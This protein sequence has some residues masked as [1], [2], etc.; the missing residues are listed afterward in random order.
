M[1]SATFSQEQIGDF[2]YRHK[3][4]QK[5]LKENNIKQFVI[6]NPESIFYLI[7]ASFEAL[8]RVIL[9]VF[10][11]D[12]SMN[13]LVPTL[14]YSHLIKS[15]KISEENIT[16]Y[17]EFPSVDGQN[18]ND[19][20]LNSNIIKKPLSIA[21]ES[22]CPL[23]VASLFPNAKVSSF[24]D[25]I[26]TIKSNLE[27]EKIK[28]AAHYA[29]LGVQ[30]ILDNTKYGTTAF[31]TAASSGVIIQ[32][33]AQN[34]PDLDL[35]VSKIL[36]SVAFPAPF[37]GEPHSS[38]NLNAPLKEGPHV[39]IVLTQLN[40]YCAESERTFFTTEPTSEE[41][42]CFN[43]MLQAREI[44]LKMIKPGQKCSEIDEAISD[45]LKN[46]GIKNYHN[47][48]H[49]VGH[50]FGLSNH[51]RPWLAE[52]GKEY[53]E[54]NMLVSMEPGIYIP[55]LGGFRH[56]DTILVTTDGA[57]LLTKIPSDLD[58]LIIKK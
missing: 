17:K 44:G 41:R 27:I 24:V 15:Y 30:Y 58:S 9:L 3:F 18:W 53:L 1:I 34:I 6:T 23:S 21:I 42:E 5:K 39:A 40:G 37:S 4:L 47:Q 32:K 16:V 28:V 10:N 35:M 36:C 29:D 38:F 19:I 11:D 20:L 49:R 13:F 14:E 45:F 26:R 22:S 48:L 43:L 50:G 46:N 31:E 2:E 56:S 33:A 12:G 55:K 25:D 51:E 57:E 52:G 54:E 8:E 7:G